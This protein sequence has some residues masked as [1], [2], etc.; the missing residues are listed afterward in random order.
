[1]IKTMTWTC[2]TQKKMDTGKVMMTRRMQEYVSRFVNIC[3]PLSQTESSNIW[4]CFTTVQLPTEP[5]P[6]FSS[7]I[8]LC[9]N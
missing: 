7:T 2:L 5:L 1:M 8:F 3:D 9:K 4:L 6:S